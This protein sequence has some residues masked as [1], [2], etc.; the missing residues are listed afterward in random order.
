MLIGCL[1]PIDISNNFVVL[2][3]QV[4]LMVIPTGLEPV[5]L[6]LENPCS[7]QLS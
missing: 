1:T 2:D 7:V 5:T 6:G 3:P 4:G